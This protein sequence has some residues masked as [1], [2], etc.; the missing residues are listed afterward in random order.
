MYHWCKTQVNSIYSYENGGGLVKPQAVTGSS[1][2]PGVTENK[3]SPSTYFLGNMKS[4]WE[5]STP[6]ARTKDK[7]GKE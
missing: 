6:Q 2:G 7:E 3:Y 4:P 5:R 1:R